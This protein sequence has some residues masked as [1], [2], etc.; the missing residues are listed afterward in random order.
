MKIKT[1]ARST[2][3][4]LV[5]VLIALGVF[6]IGMVAVASLFPV[7]ALL[8]KQTIEEVLGEH[9]AQSAKS[10]VEAK[11]LT[12]EAPAT[13]LTGK[14]DL[15]PYHTQAGSVHSYAV[16]LSFVNADLVLKK[17]TYWDR[18]YPSA[19][20]LPAD[21]DLFWVPFVQNISGEVTKPNW[22][23]R[24]F[25]LKPDANVNYNVSAG[26]RSR[27]ANPDDPPFF[28][29]V[30]SIG[31][32]VKDENTFTLSASNHGLE[33]GDLIMDNNGTDYKIA[34]VKGA[35]VKVLGRILES[36]ESPRFI[37]Y[38]PTYGGN[39]SPTLRIVTV[40]IDVPQP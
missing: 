17:Y 21:R 35:E 39:A 30:L 6:A 40:K 8:Q 33:G 11:R 12:Y 14:G 23:M 2:G 18:S 5:E 32:K 19:I 16:P 27:C 31:C 9:A 15:G 25:L 26:D 10:I 3:F 24:L 34:E 29:K 22:V 13:G 38:A 36:P 37:W 4:T 20:P 1:P 7:A 28:P